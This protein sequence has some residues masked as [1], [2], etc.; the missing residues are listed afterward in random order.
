MVT[1]LGVPLIGTL[2]L[3]TLLAIITFCVIWSLSTRKK[4]ATCASGLISAGKGPNELPFT[5]NAVVSKSKKKVLK[6]RVAS[7]SSVVSDDKSSSEGSINSSSK[8]EVYCT[9]NAKRKV[10][11]SKAGY[12]SSQTLL[13]ESDLTKKN[14]RNK[15]CKGQNG[16][17]SKKKGASNT[18]EGTIETLTVFYGTHTETSKVKYTLAS[19]PSSYCCITVHGLFTIGYKVHDQV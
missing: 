8:L 18:L 2:F 13:L 10:F 16:C 4:D 12:Q 9:G 1:V 11:R 5:V 17:C 3:P 14:V 7:S 6:N 15:K 19:H